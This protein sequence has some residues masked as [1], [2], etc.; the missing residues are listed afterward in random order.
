[1]YVHLI[2]RETTLRVAANVPSI[3]FVR[4][5]QLPLSCH[6]SATPLLKP[7]QNTCSHEPCHSVSTAIDTR[8]ERERSSVWVSEDPSSAQLALRA[9]QLN[10]HAGVAVACAQHR[11]GQRP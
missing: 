5:D 4:L 10:R 7:S 6:F 11:T 1:M 3:A 8:L 9:Q 2:A